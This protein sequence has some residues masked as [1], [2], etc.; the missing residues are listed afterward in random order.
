MMVFNIDNAYF[1]E[2]QVV[3]YV[4]CNRNYSDPRS[5][6]QI[7]NNGTDDLYKLKKQLSK[8]HE[9]SKHPKQTSYF[10]LPQPSAVGSLNS[11][12]P[13]SQ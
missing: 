9:Q 6:A 11:K 5:I 13:Q 10:Q 4:N 7:K 3:G 8:P 1:D 2:V 12:T